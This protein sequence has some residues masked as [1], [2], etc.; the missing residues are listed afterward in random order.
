MTSA[1]QARVHNGRITLDEPTD[2][3]DGT[4]LE[5][6]LSVEMNAFDDEGHEKLH[7]TIRRGAEQDRITV[8]GKRRFGALKGKISIDARFDEPLPDDELGEWNL[9]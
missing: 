8:R 6:V 7:T 1:L 3:P 2:L 9:A 4:V 5:L